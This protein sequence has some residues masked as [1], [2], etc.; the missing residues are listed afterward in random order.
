MLA[1]R[2]HRSISC[3]LGEFN[4]H[5]V[6]AEPGGLL[7]GG[8]GVCHVLPMGVPVRQLCDESDRSSASRL[9]AYSATTQ[10]F[11]LPRS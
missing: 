4:Y 8:P 1:F 11:L 7:I 10:T 5:L 6:G 9:S 2:P 3:I